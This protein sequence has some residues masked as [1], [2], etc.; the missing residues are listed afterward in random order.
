VSVSASPQ[1]AEL[2]RGARA[3]VR[4]ARRRASLVEA[5]E[6]LQERN[7]EGR[8]L[9]ARP[10]TTAALAAFQQALEL[11][12]GDAQLVHHLA[13]ARHALAW[14][15]ELAGDP[16]AAAEWEAALGHW[17]ALVSSAEFWGELE[18]KLG[19]MDAAVMASAVPDLRRDLLERVLEVHVDFIRHYCE[20]GNPRRAQAH[21]EIVQRAAIAPAVK[22][23]LVDRVFVDLTRAVPQAREQDDFE[24]ALVLV[25]RFLALFPR[26]VPALR[27]AAEVATAWLGGLGYQSRWSDVLAVAAR[28]RPVAVELVAQQAGGI[29]PLAARALEELVAEVTDRAEGRARSAIVA[30]DDD[31]LRRAAELGVEWAGDVW[32]RTAARSV[33]RFNFAACVFYKA[34]L[35]QMDAKATLDVDDVARHTA[36]ELATDLYQEA[37]RLIDVAL[38]AS[39]DDAAIIQRHEEIHRIHRALSHKVLP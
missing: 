9:G 36:D 2:V 6:A 37:A 13:I 26:H 10:H 4:D 22:K 19:E 17:R 12:P 23:R 15:L 28:V 1:I 39:P 32:R 21:V 35:L 20:A 3:V 14:D 29:E 27:L 8:A 33:V 38:E 30:R 34:Q 16:R 25:E 11:D 31:D 7:G 24:S 5:W 18:R